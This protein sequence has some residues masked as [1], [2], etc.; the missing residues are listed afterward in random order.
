MSDNIFICKICNKSFN[1]K[2]LRKKEIR[3]IFYYIE[4]TYGKHYLTQFKNHK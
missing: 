4:K 3:N 2:I 1:I